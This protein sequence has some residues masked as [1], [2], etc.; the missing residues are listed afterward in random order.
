[1]RVFFLIER[2]P[3]CLFLFSV[4][5]KQSIYVCISTS[6]LYRRTIG[7]LCPLRWQNCGNYLGDWLSILLFLVYSLFAVYFICC[8]FCGRH[9]LHVLSSSV[10]CGA[11][12][13]TNYMSFWCELLIKSFVRKCNRWGSR[14]VEKSRQLMFMF[15]SMWL[16]LL[17]H[18]LP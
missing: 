11:L 4:V 9:W 12:N 7:S 17:C 13:Y 16:F 18:K 3:P 8:C 6:V 10:P 14:C 5:K 2:I 15:S 1:M